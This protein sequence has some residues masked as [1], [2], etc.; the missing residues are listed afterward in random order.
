MNCLRW[1]FYVNVVDD[2]DVVWV[3]FFG[4]CACVDGDDFGSDVGGDVA[5]DGDGI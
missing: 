2:V 1:L 5:D 3:M 4:C